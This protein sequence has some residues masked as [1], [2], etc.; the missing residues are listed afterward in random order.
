V[1]TFIVAT[2]VPETSRMH[3]EVL[4]GG[5]VDPMPLTSDLSTTP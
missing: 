1:A 4:E 3:D 2:L 5:L